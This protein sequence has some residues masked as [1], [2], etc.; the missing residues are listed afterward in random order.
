MG[1]V[2]SVY[3]IEGGRVEARDIKNLALGL[4]SAAVV[5][6]LLTRTSNDYRWFLWEVKDLG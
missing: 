2:E 5:G 1:A 4:T 3:G 6:G